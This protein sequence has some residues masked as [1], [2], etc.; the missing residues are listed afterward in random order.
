MSS[1]TKELDT[2]DILAQAY[3][4]LEV[5]EEQLDKL[6]TEASDNAVAMTEASK[7]RDS[8]GFF[9]KQ[10]R[11]NEMAAELHFAKVQVAQAK[12]AVEEARLKKAQ[13][14][15]PPLLERMAAIR[16]EMAPL[17]AQLAAVGYQAS[18]RER[19][20][21]NHASAKAPLVR[22][23]ENLEGEWRQ[24]I[25]LENAPSVRSLQGFVR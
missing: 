4:D 13:Q 17:E 3:H 19:I 20:K 1:K 9:A 21:R 14:E 25:A 8:A 6:Q 2:V 5:A 16:A 12:I 22:Q 23:L 18:Q 11:Q 15:L 7:A 10:K 24:R